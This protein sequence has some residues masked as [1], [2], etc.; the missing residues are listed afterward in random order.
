MEKINYVQIA[1]TPQRAIA[2][3]NIS[4]RILRILSMLATTEKFDTFVCQL[5]PLQLSISKRADPRSFPAETPQKGE[6]ILPR[7]PAC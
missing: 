6:H 7:I 1:N 4:D 5:P 3:E 2:N